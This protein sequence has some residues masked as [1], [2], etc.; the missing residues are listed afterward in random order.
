M[1]EIFTSVGYDHTDALRA[2]QIFPGIAA[3]ENAHRDFLVTT[4]RYERFMSGESIDEWVGLLGTDVL[5]LTH[6][7]VTEV[8]ARQ[9]SDCSVQA[10]IEV[11]DSER[12]VLEAASR[13]HDFG[14][15]KDDVGGI[16]DISHDKKQPFHR[17]QETVVFQR[18]LQR[19]INQDPYQAE[20]MRQTYQNVV[21][22][23]QNSELARKFNAIE[24]IGYLFVAHRAFT[25]A[26][27]ERIRNWK[28][29][30]GNVLS[31][32]TASLIKYSQEYPMARSLLGILEDDISAMF[33]DTVSSEPEIDSEGTLSFDPV[34]LHTASDIWAQFRAA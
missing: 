14:E 17:E 2:E 27:G 26:N 20:F 9:F 11:S 22:G 12:I 16:G 10:G 8:I 30:V 5:S 21:H 29:L 32:Q 24:R 19:H 33:L 15:I 13:I 34:R 28:G 1:I 4:P 7:H 25:G 3:I 23:D 6:P 18:L 31:N